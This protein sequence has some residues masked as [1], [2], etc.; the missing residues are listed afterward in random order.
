MADISTIVTTDK[1]SYFDTSR[2]QKIVPDE[3][4][5]WKSYFGTSKRDCKIRPISNGRFLVRDYTFNEK[6]M[7]TIIY[8]GGISHI[9]YFGKDD[10]LAF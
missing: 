5:N 4:E 9:H 2:M 1:V 10:Y 7:T 8:P 3:Y 6:G